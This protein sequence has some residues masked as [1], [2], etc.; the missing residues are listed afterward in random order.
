M[1]SCDMKKYCFKCLAAHS[2]FQDILHHIPQAV[3]QPSQI[4]QNTRV[5]NRIYRALEGSVLGSFLIVVLGDR[6]S[7]FISSVL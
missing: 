2:E 7:V 6:I 4:W 3:H 1:K 5:R